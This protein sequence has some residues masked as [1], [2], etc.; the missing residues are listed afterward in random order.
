VT[1]T[2]WIVVVASIE[3]L[4]D[5][6]SLGRKGR[7]ANTRELIGPNWPYII[8]YQIREDCNRFM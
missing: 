4:A 3:K 1:L 2:V 8:P 6:P 7:V 5:F